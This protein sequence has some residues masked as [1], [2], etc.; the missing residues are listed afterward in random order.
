MTQDGHCSYLPGNEWV[1]NDAYPDADRMQR[2]YLYHVPTGRRVELGDLYSPPRYDGEWRCDLHP[3]SSPDGRRVVVDSA[4]D[5]NGR[6]M[7]IL[8]ISGTVVQ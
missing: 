1:L 2:L 4:H 5:G 7:H 6:Q 3:R 8:D